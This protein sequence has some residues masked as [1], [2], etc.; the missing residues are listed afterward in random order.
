MQLQMV[1]FDFKEEGT[2][3]ELVAIAT[4]KG[5]PSGISLSVQQSCKISIA[6]LH[7]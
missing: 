1:I 2:G 4:V 6:L 7:Y 3:N 5:V